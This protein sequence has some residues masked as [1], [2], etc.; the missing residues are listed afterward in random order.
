METIITFRLFQSSKLAGIH[1][2]QV[3]LKSPPAMT[4]TAS[5]RM[6]PATLQR[7]GGARVVCIDITN[8]PSRQF[9]TICSLHQPQ[10]RTSLTH[11]AWRCQGA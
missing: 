6:W 5:V 11:T 8:Q 10:G 1:S 7:L 9:H 3:L 2:A 4:L